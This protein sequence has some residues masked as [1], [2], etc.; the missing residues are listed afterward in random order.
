MARWNVSPELEEGAG[1]KVFLADNKKQTSNFKCKTKTLADELSISSKWLR[2]ET[3]TVSGS[4]NVLCLH[5]PFLKVFK[6]GGAKS[7]L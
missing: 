2:D 7:Q 5:A 3:A 6:A 1:G 4:R